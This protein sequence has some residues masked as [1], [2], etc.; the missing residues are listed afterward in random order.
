MSW[1]GFGS[2]WD[3]HIDP[4]GNL[5]GTEDEWN[6]E[7]PDDVGSDWWWERR[8]EQARREQE[9]EDR[10]WPKGPYR[11]P[12]RKPPNPWRSPAETR[13]EGLNPWA[14]NYRNNPWRRKWRN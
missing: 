9:E 4:F 13:E 1:F 12:E 7:Y 2:A 11:E 5:R 8:K 6:S 10:W 14:S 3:A